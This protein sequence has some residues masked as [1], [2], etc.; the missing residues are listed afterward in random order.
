MLLWSLHAFGK[1]KEEPNG[2]I[3]SSSISWCISL[4]HYQEVSVQTGNLN[5]LKSWINFLPVLDKAFSMHCSTIG[6]QI[7]PWPLKEEIKSWITIS[8]WEFGTSWRIKYQDRGCSERLQKIL[9]SE[10]LQSLHCLRWI[11]E[12]DI[13]ASSTWSSFIQTLPQL[14]RTRSSICLTWY[15]LN[16][17]S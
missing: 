11:N 17:V 5:N 2:K 3:R 10:A 13:P 12:Q 1:V 7:P 9:F 15:I 14:I 6:T 16:S 8:L 4:L